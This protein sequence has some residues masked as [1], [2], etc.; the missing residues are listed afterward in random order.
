IVLLKRQ[1]NPK[2]TDKVTDVNVIKEWRN[3]I[4]NIC[5]KKGIT[6]RSKDNHSGLKSLSMKFVLNSTGEVKTPIKDILVP[7]QT[8]SECPENVNCDCYCIQDDCFNQRFEI[9]F[10]NCELTVPV[11]TIENETY[12]LHITAV[13]RA[14]INTSIIKELE[15]K[16]LND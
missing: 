13:N 6:I 8:Q 4:L 11:E 14:L 15:D 7:L 9:Y 12:S 1:L 16:D 3:R 2:T 5:Q 10:D